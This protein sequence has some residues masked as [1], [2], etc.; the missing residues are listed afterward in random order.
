MG[1]NFITR[2]DKSDSLRPIL[3]QEETE[4]EQGEQRVISLDPTAS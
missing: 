2:L 3:N 1:S 4:T